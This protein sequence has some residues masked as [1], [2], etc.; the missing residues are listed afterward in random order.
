[1][2]ST[3]PT[4]FFNR[5]Q[6]NLI[7][8]LVKM[9]ISII[10]KSFFLFC[11]RSDHLSVFACES[12][13]VLQSPEGVILGRGGV[14]RLAGRGGEIERWQRQVYFMEPRHTT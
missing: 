3:V 14:R 13:E 2:D 8:I 12:E 9:K 6:I 5:L 11:E 4:I 7:Y 10:I 1:M